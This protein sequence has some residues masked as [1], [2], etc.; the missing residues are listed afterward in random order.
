MAVKVILVEPEKGG[1]IGAIA[2]SMKNFDLDDLRIV[3]PKVTIDGEARAYAMHGLDVLDNSKV[4]RTFEEALDGVDMI[5]GTSAVVARSTS[6]LSRVA[7]T[8]R[9]FAERVGASKGNIGI[10]FGR[11]ST[12]LNRQEVELCDILVTIPA[13]RNY[14]VLNV[15]TC[16]SIIFYELFQ[17]K[18][19]E[20]V[21]LASSTSKQR[22]QVQFDRL[23]KRD[24]IQP[25]RRRLAQRAFRN[26]ISRSFISRRE[27]SLLIGVFRKA[28]AKTV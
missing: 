16:A 6:N 11:E 24:E 22:L 3:N 7:I 27:A 5:A 1:N 21:D 12:G 4:V 13:S 9:R 23:M 15:A 2:R 26:I 18:A 28:T 25:H 20:S 10:V 14:N 19:T 8:P 17:R